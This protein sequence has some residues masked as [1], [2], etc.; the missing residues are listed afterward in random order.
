VARCPGAPATTTTTTPASAASRPA[1]AVRYEW[2]APFANAD[3]NLL[4]AEGFGHAALDIDWWSQVQRHSLGWVCAYD[5]ER[6]VGFV[7]VAWDGG[8]HAFVVDT[9]VAEDRRRAGIGK[10]LLAMAVT[11]CRR[12]RCEWVHVDFGEELG[13][14]YLGA[15][16]FR[17]TPGGLIGLGASAEQPG[18]G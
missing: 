8:L 14:F 16:G 5:D 9:L 12:A 2:R 3:V 11:E 6:L 17:P 7:N 15:S 1:F 13:D 4:H 10:G 18:S